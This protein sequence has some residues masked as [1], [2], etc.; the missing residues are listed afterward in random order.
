MRSKSLGGD[1]PSGSILSSP[2]IDSAGVPTST[3]IED[4]NQDMTSRPQQGRLSPQIVHVRGVGPENAQ[5]LTPNQSTPKKGTIWPDGNSKWALAE[6][7]RHALT[8]GS[9]NAG[10][11][12]SVN[13]IVKIIDQNPSYTELCEMLELRGFIIDRGHFAR[14]LLLAVSGTDIPSQLQSSH[15]QMRTNGFNGSMGGHGQGMMDS[16]LFDLFCL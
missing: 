11:I 9:A 12:I 10:R 5:D 6:A 15:T 7:A 8:S 4:S 14:L 2:S 16:F 13:E 3:V 1:I